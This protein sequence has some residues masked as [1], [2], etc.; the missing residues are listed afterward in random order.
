[1]LRRTLRAR[2]GDSGPA[3]SYVIK[4][5]IASIVAAAAAWAVKL[6]LPPLIPAL[7]AVVVLGTYALIFFGA[8]FALRVPE[9]ASSL[10]RV[11]RMLS[12]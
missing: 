8:V 3:A 4:L 9:A 12:R 6:M 7:T 11:R 1:M 10:A 2:I 5:W